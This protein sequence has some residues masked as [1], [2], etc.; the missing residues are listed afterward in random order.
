VGTSPQ[1]GFLNL[2][3]QAAHVL[4]SRTPAARSAILDGPDE[5]LSS[6]RSVVL[7]I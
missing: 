5:R 4:P 7:L 6:L 2:A 3:A 1:Q